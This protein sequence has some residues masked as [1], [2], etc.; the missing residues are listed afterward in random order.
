MKQDP[1]NQQV[2]DLNHQTLKLK[3]NLNQLLPA[4]G[5]PVNERKKV[6]QHQG[7]NLHSQD[8]KLR[9]AVIA[10]H[11]QDHLHLHHLLRQEETAVVVVREIGEDNHESG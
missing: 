8:M 11:H 2:R 4:E 10:A 7:E 6:I 5:V 9:E 1:K 3:K